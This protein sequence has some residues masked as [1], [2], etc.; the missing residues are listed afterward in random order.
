MSTPEPL[1]GIAPL[2]SLSFA[3][4]WHNS[5]FFSGTV[6][7]TLYVREKKDVLFGAYNPVRQCAALNR[8][9]VPN[10]SEYAAT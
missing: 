9:G 5:Y 10:K 7:M 1:M 6:T 4:A 3:R 8:N 2:C